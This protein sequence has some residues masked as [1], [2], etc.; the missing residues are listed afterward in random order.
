[1]KSRVVLAALAVAAVGAIG[2]GPR[3]V[4]DPLRALVGWVAAYGFALGTVLGALILTMVFTVTRASWPIVLW[5]VLSAI[6]RTMPIFA[7][8]F[9]PIAIG[10]RA[11][12]PWAPPGVGTV[13]RRAARRRARSGARAPTPVEHPTF[14]LVRAAIYL[15][16]WIVIAVLVHRSRGLRA[17]RV[18]AAG[19]VIVAFTLTFA[20]FDWFMSLEPGWVANMYGLYFFAGGF[21]SA[22]STVALLAWA[23]SRSGRLVGMKPDHFHALGRL[24]LMSTIF[25]SYIAF[26]QLMLVWI[27]DLPREV[28]FYLARARGPYLAVDALLLFGHFLLPFLALLSRGLKRRPALLAMVGS[29]IILMDAVDLT[30]LVLPSAGVDP[31]ALDLAPF[32]FIGG[33]AIAY[34]ARPRLRGRAGA[35]PRARG[36][37]GVPLVMTAPRDPFVV[38][39]EVDALDRRRLARSAASS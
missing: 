27:A 21:A 29:W 38:E 23:S 15:A 25:W 17:R 4:Q 8:L 33:V 2:G 16:A 34:G 9:V 3:G 20:A 1:M 6:T 18:S 32:L 24:M 19:L 7:L 28:T 14:F 36:V 11:L 31:R 37:P 35:R 13:S 22:V 26:F 12:Y 39:Q 10:T 5:P 30:W